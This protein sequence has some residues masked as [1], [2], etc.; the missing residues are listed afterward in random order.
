MKWTAIMLAGDEGASNID[1]YAEGPTDDNE[2]I[3][4]GAHLMLLAPA[5]ML[6]RFQRTRKTAV[7]MSCGKARHTLT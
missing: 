7:R 4:E 5:A 2:W 3:R 6:K 1:P